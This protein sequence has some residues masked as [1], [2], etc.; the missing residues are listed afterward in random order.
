VRIETSTSISHITSEYVQIDT[1]EDM[2]L[3]EADTVVVSA[4]PLPNTRFASQAEERG[5]SVDVV[6]SAAGTKGLLEIV[7]S[8]FK[9]ANNLQL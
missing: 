3:I 9:Y 8:A 4:E 1:P 6:G 5:L 2:T 7:H